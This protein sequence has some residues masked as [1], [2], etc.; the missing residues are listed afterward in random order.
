M[1]MKLVIFG[2]T[3]SSSWGNGHATLWRGLVHE[4]TE[5][6]HQVV[7]FEKDVAYYAEHR[8]LTVI[9]GGEL[10]FYSDFAAY[11]RLGRSITSAT[12]YKY[13]SG[14][15]P[16]ALPPPRPIAGIP[17]VK[18]IRTPL[19]RIMRDLRRIQPK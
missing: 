12:Y 19:A 4:L 10:V 17:S 11:A 18:K 14:P 3:I 13:P 2:L 16:Q 1:R 5:R 8:D 15:F 7:F 6:G 9:D